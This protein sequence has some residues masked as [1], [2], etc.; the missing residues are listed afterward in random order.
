MGGRWLFVSL[1]VLLSASDRVVHGGERWGVSSPHL[2]A[3]ASAFAR[4]CPASGAV[5][6]WGS[7][8]VAASAPA[9]RAAAELA[10]AHDAFAAVMRDGSVSAWGQPLFGGTVNTE[11]ATWQLGQN[12]TTRLYAGHS[13]FAAVSEEGALAAWGYP[14]Y[15]GDLSRLSSFF[16]SQQVTSVVA[17]KQAFAALT[18]SGSVRAWGTAADGGDSATVNGY[19]VGVDTIYSADQAFAAVA[20]AGRRIVAWGSEGYGGST[21]TVAALV[22]ESGT[23]TFHSV[24]ATRGAFAALGSDGRVIVWG[25]RDA[26]GDAHTVAARLAAGVRSVAATRS[27]FAAVV[28]GGG[29]LDSHDGTSSEASEIV[30]WED[31]AYFGCPCGGDASAVNEE[32]RKPVGGSGSGS[33]PRY[34]TVAKVVA[35]DRAF[36][37][38]LSDGSVLAWGR[39]EGGG[40]A[41]TVAALLRSGVADVTPAGKAFAARTVGGTVVAWGSP[42]HGGDAATVAAQLVGVTEVAS[43]GAAFA[44]YSAAGGVVVAWGDALSGGDAG[45]VAPCDA[46]AVPVPTTAEPKTAPKTEAPT[47]QPTPQPTTTPRTAA[48]PLAAVETEG[49]PTAQ[50][51]PPVGAATQHPSTFAGA[52]GSESRVE[53]R[54]VV[55]LAVPALLALLVAAGIYYRFVRG[56]KEGG[57]GGGD[58]AGGPHGPEGVELDE[59]ERHNVP[60]NLMPEGEEDDDDDMM[61][62]AGG[63]A[64]G[65]LSVVLPGMGG[66]AGVGGGGGGGEEDL[67]QDDGFFDD[68]DD[69]IQLMGQLK[70]AS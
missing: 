21:S 22:S 66:D 12:E 32:L 55:K 70:L 44:A 38:L 60:G 40:D 43:T 31:A 11:K 68:D 13:A 10:C 37:A 57:G 16:T 69:E 3:A 6:S 27:A 59:L 47:P 20:G 64:G 62:G 14:E 4:L 18:A 7:R 35:A 50:P 46:A 34:R 49:P 28:G 53:V 9:G 30:A 1:A 52:G 2:C 42:H 19:L 24:V 36:A 29:L 63:R 65:G 45:T 61:Y 41:A 54:G 33:A 25:A 26:G 56:G 23:R 5:S 8:Q 39:A 15:G 58:G 51:L 17:S 48:P 67:F